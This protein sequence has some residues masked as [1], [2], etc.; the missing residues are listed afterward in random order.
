MKA[1]PGCNNPIPSNNACVV[2]PS[3]L[4]MALDSL[5]TNQI[6]P[7]SSDVRLLTIFPA[8]IRI[9]IVSDS[10]GLP[11]TTTGDNEFVPELGQFY[12]IAVKKIE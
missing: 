5:N 3:N 6:V 2:G 8:Q 7:F 9:R 10:S 4:N 11:V 12:Q 1:L